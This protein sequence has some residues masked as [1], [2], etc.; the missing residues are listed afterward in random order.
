MSDQKEP[1]SLD[2]ASQVLSAQRSEEGR[3]RWGSFGRQLEQA[4]RLLLVLSSLGFLLSLGLEYIHWATYLRPTSDSFCSLGQALDCA[5]VAAS[6]Y[7]VA[8][9]LPWAVW[10]ALGFLAIM[11]A[12]IR[13][14]VWLLPLSLLGGLASVVLLALSLFAVHSVCVLCEIAHL[15]SWL[16]CGL[17]FKQARH[18][19]GT[20]R[21]TSTLLD[22]T[23]APAGLAV[24][25]LVFLPRYWDAFS[26]K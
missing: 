9:G 2:G 1:I 19:S 7:S 16:I 23:V 21:D 10:G 20:W 14:S 24:A 11:I 22:I 13:R 5:A 15:L 6:K 18:L 3:G 25:L 12:V 26:F 17:A 8:F 4:P